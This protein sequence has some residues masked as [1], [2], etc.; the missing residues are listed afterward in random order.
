MGK[1]PVKNIKENDF[2]DMCDIVENLSE[3]ITNGYYPTVEEL[4]ARNLKNR[5]LDSDVLPFF[6]YFASNPFKKMDMSQKDEP[7]YL[8]TV[9]YCSDIIQSIEL[10]EQ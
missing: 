9:K 7:E 1:N 5:I 4:E 2:Y 3:N 6:I 8:R 10:I